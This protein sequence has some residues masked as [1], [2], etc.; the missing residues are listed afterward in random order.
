MKPINANNYKEFEEEIKMLQTEHFQLQS[1]FK[2]APIGIG[3]VID[4]KIKFVDELFTKIVGY[5]AE[6]LIGQNSMI[7]Y[8]SEEELKKYR[9]NLEE[10][11]KMRTTELEEKN[12]DLEKFNELF[13]GREF[14]IKELREEIKELK[15]KLLNKNT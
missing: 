8:P 13:V 4:R 3:V 6:E 7:V 15:L 12:L 1:I 9:D 5:T 2:V 10:L 14:R 11:V